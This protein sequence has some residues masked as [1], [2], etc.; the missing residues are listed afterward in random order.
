MTDSEDVKAGMYPGERLKFVA[1]LSC[2]AADRVLQ[3]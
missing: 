3:D 1:L 2:C